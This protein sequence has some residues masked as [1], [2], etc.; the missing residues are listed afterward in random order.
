M[1]GRD[2]PEDRGFLSRWSRMK[3]E[4]GRPAEPVPE[5]TAVPV[6]AETAPEELVDEDAIT[7]E[8]IAA[9]PPVESVTD[10]AGLEPFFRKG[11]P[12]ALRNAARRRMWMMNPKIADYLDVARDYAYDWNTPGGVPGSGGPLAPGMATQLVEKMI[13]RGE[14]RKVAEGEESRARVAA[15]AASTDE[16]PG[17]TEDRPQRTAADIKPAEVESG[18][19][20]LPEG[21][22]AESQVSTE[23]LSKTNTFVQ[24]ASPGGT[25][26]A[27]EDTP[28]AVPRRHGG[29]APR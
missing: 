24:Y 23:I 2:E 17:D 10:R 6:P 22:N 13:S 5:E 25:D 19:E 14:W 29:A 3:R 12:A 26:R 18:S 4:T 20:S 27:G 28:I 1:S 21:A 11:V 15:N 16:Q 9:L 8:E 7:E